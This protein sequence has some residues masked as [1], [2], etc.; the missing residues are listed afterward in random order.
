MW[1]WKD[2]LPISI[3]R[4]GLYSNIRIHDIIPHTN[5]WQV[6]SGHQ[7]TTIFSPLF[8]I[9]EYPPRTS[10]YCAIYEI[11]IAYTCYRAFCAIIDS[12]C[13][14]ASPLTS[15]SWCSPPLLFLSM[16]LFHLLPS[17]QI[18]YGD[19]S[20]VYLPLTP[21]SLCTWK[22]KFRL[23]FFLAIDYSV[24]SW[25]FA[26]SLRY[27]S[28]QFWLLSLVANAWWRKKQWEC[29]PAAKDSQIVKI[30]LC[31]VSYNFC[32]IDSGKHS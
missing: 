16:P 17:G 6:S 31:R 4:Q 20:T 27:S 14:L 28:L 30:N 11:F 12:P 25:V 23:F 24:I 3:C 29:P 32:D 18:N 5:S 9:F 10:R 7:Q 22:H 26:L 1:P 2:P 21:T 19:G 15:K 8:G 13:L